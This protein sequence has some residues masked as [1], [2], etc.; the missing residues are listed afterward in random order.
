M[1][2]IPTLALS[3]LCLPISAQSVSRMS[4]LQPE[5]KAAA[6]AITLNGKLSVQGNSDFRQLR[7]LCYQ[8]RTVDLSEADCPNIPINA[9]HSRHQLEQVTLPTNVRTL[10][11]IHI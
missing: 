1:R 8:L 3:L 9:F 10:S 7:D 11:L 5:Q 2:I 4:N 6:T